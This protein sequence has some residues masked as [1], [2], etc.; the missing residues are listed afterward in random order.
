MIRK[1]LIDR[2]AAS[3]VEFALVLPLLLIFL[4]GIID[5][6]RWMWVNN[7]AQ[8]AAQM[9]ARFAVV[10]KPVSSAIDAELRRC[11]LAAADPGRSDPRELFLFGHLHKFTTCTQRDEGRARLSLRFSTE[12]I[13]SCRSLGLRMSG[14]NIRPR[15]LAMPAIRTGLTSR[16]S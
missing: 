7:K 15:A 2:T 11:V 8:K 5:V 12:C 10:T 16:L 4:L 14:L 3:A 6:G 1:L 9:G 13:S